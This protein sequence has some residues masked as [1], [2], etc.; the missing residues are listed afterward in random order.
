[1]KIIVT[2]K[3]I[4]ISERIQDAIDKKFEK[5]GKFFADDIKANVVIH[6]ERDKVKVEATIVTKGT[7]FRAEDVEQD[8]FDCID[9]VADKLTTQI[10]KYK[11]KL[12][13][14]NKSNESVRFEMIPEI[15]DAE[16][17]TKVVKTKKLQLVPMSVEDAALQMELLQHN[18][19]VFIDVETE[20]VC[21]V[22]KRNDADYGVLET[23]Y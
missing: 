7:I 3:N 23:T 1:M 2:G 4:S 22:Y 12:Q 15:P 11:K 21:V 16:E 5:I 6:P 13:K 10:T 18:F 8:V 20:G 17:E 14:K 19:Y 9:T